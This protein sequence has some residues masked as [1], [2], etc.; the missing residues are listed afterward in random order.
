VESF[1]KLSVRYLCQK[2]FGY[3]SVNAMHEATRRRS[4]QKCV[5]RWQSG[6][7]AGAFDK[8]QE[9]CAR[10]QQL[11]ITCGKIIMRWKNMGMCVSFSKWAAD[12]GEYSH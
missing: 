11:K 6:K 12:T 5:Q 10:E 4:L 3:L 9:A 8:W 2:V 7:V 1:Q